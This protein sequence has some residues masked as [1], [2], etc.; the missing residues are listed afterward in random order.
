[1]TQSSPADTPEAVVDTPVEVSDEQVLILATPGR[2]DNASAIQSSELPPD[3]TSLLATLQM[4]VG[5]NEPSVN[6]VPENLNVTDEVPEAQEDE[7]AEQ[8]EIEFSNR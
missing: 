4:I 8:S 3:T 6:P 1:L 5:A 2:L 7:N